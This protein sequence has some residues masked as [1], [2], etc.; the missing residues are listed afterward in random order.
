MGN[1]IYSEIYQHHHSTVFF[2]FIIEKAFIFK[3][4]RFSLAKIDFKKY[5]YLSKLR[6]L[7]EQFAA[8]NYDLCN[9]KTSKAKILLIYSY[10][11]DILLQLI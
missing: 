10:K 3:L 11:V 9:P 1:N 7:V 5:I 8:L 6:S 4:Y 2:C